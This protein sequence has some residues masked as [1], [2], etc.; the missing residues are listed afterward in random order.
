MK[1]SSLCIYT[2]AGF[3][4]NLSLSGDLSRSKICWKLNFLLFVLHLVI[5][6][7]YLK[8]ASDSVHF[9][10][11]PFYCPCLSSAAGHQSH[12][13]KRCY[14]HNPGWVDSMG[15]HTFQSYFHTRHRKGKGQN[16]DPKPSNAAGVEGQG[17]SLFIIQ[18]ATQW[19]QIRRRVMCLLRL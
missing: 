11:F 3:I 15:R 7:I 6:R 8:P 12:H 2:R 13:D 17:C 9:K 18:E 1:K 14:T 10:Q 5:E 19:R 16:P 4:L